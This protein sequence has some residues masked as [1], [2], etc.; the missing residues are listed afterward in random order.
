MSDE[1][2][3]PHTGNE[4][5]LGRLAVGAKATIHGVEGGGGAGGGDRGHIESGAQAG[6]ALFGEGAAP[7]LTGA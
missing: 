7:W 3:F 5:D 1:E 4:G 6:V 2:E